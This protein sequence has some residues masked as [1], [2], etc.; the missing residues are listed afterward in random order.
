MIRNVGLR[1]A[2][3]LLG[4]KPQLL[5]Y[6]LVAHDMPEWLSKLRQFLQKL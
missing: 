6:A 1:L 2:N 3:T 4:I 5:S